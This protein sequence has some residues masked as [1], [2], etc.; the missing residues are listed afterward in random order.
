ML[1]LYST[2]DFHHPELKS[3]R[4]LVIPVLLGTF[5]RNIGL[6]TTW[7]KPTREYSE[8]VVRW[9]QDFR[10]TAD[11]LETRSDIDM[12]KLGFYGYSWGGWNGPVVMALDDRFKAGVYISGGIPPTL[13]RPEAS[14]ASFAARV[15]APVLMIS[16]KDDVLRPVATYQ[17]P[18][19]DLIGT[20]DE[21]KKHLILEGGHNPPHNQVVSETLKWFDEHL[22][23]V[24]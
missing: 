7:P 16:G 8:H 15:S 1:V 21:L 12:S 11:Y 9:I 14:S 10:R 20:S 6:D 5:E 19:F 24:Q 3:G 13:A 17:A 18:M 23:L 4:A 2:L 22:G